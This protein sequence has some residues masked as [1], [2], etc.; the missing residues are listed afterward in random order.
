MYPIPGSN[1]VLE[2]GRMAN[3]A[4]GK[5]TDYEEVWIDLDIVKVGTKEKFV[6]WVLTVEGSDPLLRGM[7]MRIG[8]WIQAILRVGDIVS[9]SRWKWKNGT[10]F[11]RILTL[12]QL[13][14]SA[15]VFGERDLTVGQTFTVGDGMQWKCTE[16]HN[17][18]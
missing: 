13:E 16:S 4:T 14:L 5:L 7:A 2:K 17:W 9:I 6:S 12:G 10:G 11:E 18:T 3:P 8:E 1:E 15:D